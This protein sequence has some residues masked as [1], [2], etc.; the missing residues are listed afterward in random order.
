[1]ISADFLNVPYAVPLVFSGGPAPDLNERELFTE[2]KFRGEDRWGEQAPKKRPGDIYVIIGAAAGMV[3]G[4]I[5]GY[6]V[7]P[8]MALVGVVA[9]G[10]VGAVTGRLLLSLLRKRKKSRSQQRRHA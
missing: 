4:G 1:V 3:G 5:L 9:G 8:F 7:N 10:V 2:L 6:F